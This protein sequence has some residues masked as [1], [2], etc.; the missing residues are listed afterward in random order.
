MQT[1]PRIK[2]CHWQVHAPAAVVS[3][4]ACTDHV[5]KTSFMVGLS[6]DLLIQDLAPVLHF[7]HC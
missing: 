3:S 4:A 7:A 5:G 2:L 6:D 1:S